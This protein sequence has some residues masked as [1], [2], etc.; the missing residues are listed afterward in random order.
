MKTL[1]ACFAI[2]LA[3]LATACTAPGDAQDKS[4]LPTN[5]QVLRG[6]ADEARIKG[7]PD[8]PIRVVEVSDFQCPYC[9]Q[10]HFETLTQIDSAYIETGKIRYIWVSFVNPGH[11]LA[12]A[13]SEAAFCAGAVGKF[14]AMHDILFERQAEWSALPDAYGAFVEYAGEIGID[15]ESFGG[16][17]R[18]SRLASLVI[19]DFSNVTRAGIN[20]TPYLII[21]DSLTLRGAADF[22]TFAGV[23]DGVLDGTTPDSAAAAPPDTASAVPGVS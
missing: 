10:F 3:V 16:C 22:A 9:R 4:I 7:S 6:A 11:D 19:S 14:W 17:V 1:S 20:S 15:E 8:A 12:F 21:A 18:N 13:S 23:V 5:G 2:I